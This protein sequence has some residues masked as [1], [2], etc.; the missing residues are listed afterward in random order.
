[1]ST[2]LSSA[3]HQFTICFT[4]GDV[5]VLY[6]RDAAHAKEVQH[7]LHYSQAPIYFVELFARDGASARINLAHVMCVTY[8][9]VQ[10][11]ESE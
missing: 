3:V 4:D 11:G 8:R 10:D 5:I 1:M 6:A 7:H 2:T 9:E